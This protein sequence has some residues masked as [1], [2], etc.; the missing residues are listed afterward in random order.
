MRQT[1]SSASA[2]LEQLISGSPSQSSG[3]PR[4]IVLGAFYFVFLF[5]VGRLYSPLSR[6]RSSIFRSHAS[7]NTPPSPPAWYA[8]TS[9]IAL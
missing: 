1:S 5:D 4:G 8:P 3:T 7:S 6:D 9:S 2:S